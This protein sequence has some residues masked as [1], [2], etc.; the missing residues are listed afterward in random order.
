MYIET[1]N[2]IL[3]GELLD[4]ICFAAEMKL[5]NECLQYEEVEVVM[6]KGKVSKINT[7][8]IVEGCNKLSKAE[9]EV[10]KEYSRYRD[11]T[12]AVLVADNEELLKQV[13]RKICTIYPPQLVYNVT[14][15][16]RCASHLDV[17]YYVKSGDGERVLFPR[18]S[19]G[20]PVGFGP[21]LSNMSEEHRSNFIMGEY[22]R[23]E[24]IAGDKRVVDKY[25]KM[26]FTEMVSVGYEHRNLQRK[27]KTMMMKSTNKKQEQTDTPIHLGASCEYD[28]VDFTHSV[29]KQ[30]LRGIESLEKNQQVDNIMPVP[31]MKLKGYMMSR[32]KFLKKLKK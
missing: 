17:C 7:G 29:I 5:Y 11:D 22:I 21:A 19:L 2:K 25:M 12:E 8:E 28:G 9:E 30:L 3:S 14:L 31:G 27:L 15:S 20:S 4:L 10:V 1:A 18:K 23:Y 32:R 13:L 26:L 16:H 6:E 24:R